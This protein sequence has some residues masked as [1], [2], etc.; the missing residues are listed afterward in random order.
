MFKYN[1]KIAI[2]VSGGKD[3]LSLLHILSK[4][5]KKRSKSRIIA[6]IIDEG[7][8]KYRDEALEI[9]ISNCNYLR[10]QYK[11]IT[12][13]KLY[14]FTLDE[15]IRKK[16]KKK[17]LS[18]C[19]ICGVLRRKAINYAGRLVNANKIATAHTLDDEVQTILLNLF[20]GDLNRLIKGSPVS[21]VVNRCFIQKVKPF[22]EI[23]EKESALYAYFK[24]IEFQS[25]PCPYASEAMRNDVRLM[26]NYMEKKHSGTKFTIFQTLEKIRPALNK[27]KN[28]TT[29]GKCASCGEPA[30]FRYCKACEVLNH[31]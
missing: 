21:G 24:K 11:I 15:I 2:A 20:H 14:G 7:I 9:A 8:E 10:I 31:N 23:L 26:L 30:S 16:G 13:K 28:K 18:S 22:C 19:A 5:Q 3:S 1:D 17:K 25:I 6:I 29:F 4:I 27:F 12:F